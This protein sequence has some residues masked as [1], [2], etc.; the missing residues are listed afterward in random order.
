[1]EEKPCIRWNIIRGLKE[2]LILQLFR[3]FH[4][5]DQLYVGGC[6]TIQ[7][8]DYNTPKITCNHLTK[9]IRSILDFMI[10]MML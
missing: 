5:L 10:I 2:L 7:D 4:N 9:L 3:F 1:V 6:G 8:V